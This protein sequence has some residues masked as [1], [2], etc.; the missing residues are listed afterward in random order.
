MMKHATGVAALATVLALAAYAVVPYPNPGGFERL[1]FNNP[2]IE[3]DLG[4]GIWSRV[5][6]L[7]Y[8]GDGRLDILEQTS[9]TPFKD[10]R[11]YL[12]TTPGRTAASPISFA[13]GVSVPETTAARADTG[14]HP[15]VSGLASPHPNKVNAQRWNFVDLDGDGMEDVVLSI[16]DWTRYGKPGP[17]CPLSY[18]ANGVWTN[19]SIATYLYYYRNEG[20]NGKDAKFA[21][22]VPI[23]AE[24]Y[25]ENVLEGP[26][27]GVDVMFH[28]WD[29]DGDMD[30]V[31]G[32]F[33]DSFW[34]FENIGGKG[35]P[36]FARGRK[37]LA[38][39]G[40]PLAV[41]LCM[42][43]PE[44]VD[45]NGDGHPD[46]IAA[47]EDGRV[48]Y[49][50]NTG[51]LKD[52]VPVFKRGRFLRQKAQE[53]KFG[54]LCT[55][56][57]V[58]WDGD[59]D[60][61]IISGNSAGYVGFIENLSGPG[62]TRPKW[63]EP[64]YFT[65]GGRPIR[66]MAGVSG[67][68]Q[69]PCEAKWGYTT[70]S[71]GDWDGD[72]ILD[73]VVNDIN[74]NA[75]IYRGKNKGGVE[76]QS[77]EPV[78]VEWEGGIQPVAFWEWRPHPGK[79]LRVPW[80]STVEMIDWNGDGLQDL[81]FM[82]VEGFL[83]FGERFKAADGSLHV[84]HPR[85]IFMDARNGKPI[86]MRNATHA[87]SGRMR[88]IL[89]DW[90]GDG[91]KDLIKIGGSS[92]V[93][94]LQ[95][96]DEDGKFF[97]RPKGGVS[98]DVM[99]GHAGSPATVDFDGDGLAELLF[100]AEDGFFYHL[101]NPHAAKKFPKGVTATNGNV[102]V[103]IEKLAQ[104]PGLDGKFTRKEN[105]YPELDATKDVPLFFSISN[106]TDRVVSGTFKVWLND[107]W[108]VDKGAENITLAP[109]ATMSVR[110]TAIPGARVLPALYPVHAQYECES[111]GNVHPVAVFRAKTPN[112]AFAV[113]KKRLENLG[114][115][116]TRLDGSF[117][118]KIF[119]INEGNE[120]EIADVDKPDTET[121]AAFYLGPAKGYRAGGIEPRRGFVCHPPYRKYKGM[122]ASDFLIA[123]PEVVPCKATFFG[124]LNAPGGQPNKG[125]GVTMRVFARTEG[126]NKFKELAAVRVEKSGMW[127][128]GVAVLDSYAGRRLTLR[129]AVDPGPNG[130]TRGDHCAWGDPVIE[131]GDV[132]PPPTEDDWRL[133]EKL[134]AERAKSALKTGTDAAQGRFLLDY[135]G[136]RYGAG[137]VPGPAGMLDGV[138]SF[139]DGEKKLAIR[140]FECDI[141]GERQRMVRED[142]ACVSAN[143][144]TLKVSWSMPGETRAKDGSPRFTRIAPGAV[145]EK[146]DRVYG[147]FGG[148]WENPRKFS[149]TGSGFIL[150][151]RHAGIDYSNGMSLVM[152][153][154]VPPNRFEVDAGLGIARLVAHNDATFFLAPSSRGAF[155]AARRFSAASGYK[156][157]A[158]FHRLRGRMCL[159]SW[160]G[161]Y[162]NE[163]VRLGNAARYG[164]THALYIQHVWQK[165]GYDVR[166][167]EQYPP[168][169]DLEEFMKMASTAKN[170]GMLF[171]IHGN[172]VDYYPDATGFSYD[173]ICFNPD[174]TPLEAWY[175]PNAHSQSY[176]WLPQAIHSKLR[177]NLALERDGF[178]PDAIFLDVFTAS[179]PK[180]VIDRSGRFHPASRNVQEWCRAWEECREVYGIGD[181]V[182]VSEAG[183]D[184]QIGHVDAGEADHW[185]P[186]RMVKDAMQ[187]DACERVPWH[188]VVSHG[189]MILF[190][191]GIEA[192][193]SGF[194][195]TGRKEDRVLH[196]YGTDDYLCTTVIGGR[197]PM[198]ASFGA[199]TVRTYWLV[200][201]A[202]AALAEGTFESFDFSGSIQHQ[203]ASFSTGDVWVNRNTNSAWTVQGRVLPGYGFL[204]LAK[205]GIEAGVTLA[206]N[207]RMAFAKSPSGIYVEANPSK[208]GDVARFGGIST[209][210]ALYFSF[211]DNM[212]RPLPGRGRFTV[213]FELGRFGCAAR[214][215]SAIE[216]V[217]LDRDASAAKPPAWKQTGNRLYLTCDAAG[218]G[219]RLIFADG[220]N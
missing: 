47:E 144:G 59:G 22:P 208:D 216:R 120:T 150:S 76:M 132:P 96:K 154:D 127:V 63:A 158:G 17:K 153:T 101:A 37:V 12:N 109:G 116:V 134:A 170:A 34:Y 27:G 80:R 197:S 70:V 205:N 136:V 30:F 74:G 114:L 169:G 18:D 209:T 185:N 54:C 124:A 103:T 164:V 161:R 111:V 146:V 196:G 26:W 94:L 3:V 1:F 5:K 28:D 190:G 60:Y 55:P 108:R 176:R 11:I 52:G 97:F 126:D 133:R 198:A 189:R 165:W 65:V 142:V 39:D 69:G 19:R 16:S 212:V 87:A 7:D 8:D 85:R 192:R 50:E 122:V 79:A 191:G 193:Y 180:D 141:D 73:M 44:K 162:A 72:G 123:I 82:D 57:G 163:A 78:E 207:M 43:H 151:T 179:L 10:S 98:E 147:G 102:S 104:Q 23:R 177:E 204:V 66:S 137:Y 105:G 219:Y 188:D 95:E 31:C 211:A 106:G 128:P 125:D 145:R 112:R 138:I 130:D 75:R 4:M 149:L 194:D 110:R 213:E 2:D 203:H 186:S 201:D 159:D 199:A 171:G 156:A 131:L 118:R 61:D 175:N 160:S 14:G 139:S 166:L 129:L 90:D 152:A 9:C 217:S 215:I 113:K 93:C 56:F 42:Y 195:D 33:I 174:G 167:P 100:G 200:H 45:F 119:V 81:V 58:D 210:G 41:D 135:G 88:W 62:V 91:R 6:A 21:E 168:R 29:R 25:A 184:T 51:R 115:G 173:L 182:T 99:Q 187:Y 107:D 67:S 49:F 143:G 53:L 89:E 183:N 214:K 157:S 24:G 40:T 202:C 48:S 68:P 121:G 206:G 92:V 172:Y 71:A 64:R 13:A 46:M 148:V 83:V 140:G 155:D 36:R 15:S 35:N 178:H 32:E 117:S 84:R 20:G 86:C 38:A 77:G 181:A 218:T 220:S